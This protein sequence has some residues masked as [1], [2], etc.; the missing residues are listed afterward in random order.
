MMRALLAVVSWAEW[1]H[2]RW[3]HGLA[4]VAVAIGVALAFAVHV[5]NASALDEFGAAVRQVNGQPD[6][7]LRAAGRTGFAETFLARVAAHPAVA[8]ASPV[9]EVDTYAFDARGQRFSLRVVGI[10]VLAA[11]PLAPALVPRPGEDADSR[12]MLD[13]PD[14]LFLNVP[15]VERLT[16]AG[17]ARDS[18]PA[19]GG[20]SA[21]PRSVR[22]QVGEGTVTLP[23]RGTVAAAG[24]PL[25]VMDIA[26][27]QERF[28]RLGR[29]T[30]IDVRLR[31]G[32]DRAAILREVA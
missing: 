30:R 6:V 17:I 28:D 22:L 18:S 26:G 31:P 3:R 20:L 25:A 11:A 14:A 4:L 8:L 19:V 9:V 24:P 1:R 12:G 2:H 10:D 5:I 23:L 7:E 16:A 32:S 13:D 29:L 15:A 21:R 27:A